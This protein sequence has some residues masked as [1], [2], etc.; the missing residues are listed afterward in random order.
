V[1]AF[2]LA[3]SASKAQQCLH[4]A[5]QSDDQRARRHAA[6]RFVAQVNAAQTRSHRELG[7]YVP[8]EVGG[9]LSEVPVGFVP[10]LVFDQWGYVLSVKDLF[11][12]CGFTLFSDEHGRIYEAHPT[13]VNEMQSLP[14]SQRN[15][16]S[17]QGS[18]PQ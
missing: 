14:A 11:D 18:T 1:M 8:L 9:V 2:L 15:D 4:K 16:A 12:P 10:R 6:A 13:R 7:R 17:S 5:T 3:P